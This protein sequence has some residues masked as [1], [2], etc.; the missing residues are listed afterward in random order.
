ME[1]LA[2]DL[3][4]YRAPFG[5]TKSYKLQ[6]KGH[7]LAENSKVITKESVEDSSSIALKTESKIKSF[8]HIMTTDGKMHDIGSFNFSKHKNLEVLAK[9][10]AAKKRSVDEPPP[11]V[12]LMKKMAIADYRSEEHTSELQSHVNIV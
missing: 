10:E 1:S 7:P 8:W 6:V 11:H 4:I 12:R 5:W 2:S 9:Y 3:E